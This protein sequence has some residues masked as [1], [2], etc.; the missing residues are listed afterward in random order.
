MVG[1]IQ[2]DFSEIRAVEGDFYGFC[3]FSMF[4]DAV[5]VLKWVLII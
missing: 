3:Q 5:E 1:V 2:K 4:D